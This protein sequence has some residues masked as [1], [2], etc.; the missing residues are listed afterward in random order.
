MIRQTHQANYEAYGYRRMWKALER[1]GEPV[2]RCHVERLM[3]SHGIQGAKRRVKPW[4]TTN[5][6]PDAVRPSDLVKRG[7]TARRP[8]ALWV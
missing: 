5:A 7:F 8:N 4:R 3:V 6:N 1:A 2:A